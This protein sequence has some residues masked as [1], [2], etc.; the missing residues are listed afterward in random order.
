[1]STAKDY[2]ELVSYAQ[3]QED[4]ILHTL[5]H[6]TKKGFY[7]DV[8]A[9]HETLHSV[10]KFFYERGWHGINIDPNV[11]LM[12][13]F[14][15][16]KRDLNLTVGVSNKRGKLHFREY[17]HHDGLSTLSQAIKDQHEAED[18]PYKDYDVE[19][20]T[21]KDIFS[22]NKV[23]NIDFL[24]VDVEG[25]EPEV[26]E[27]NDWKKYRPAVVTFEGTYIDK[28]REYLKSKDYHEVFFDGLNV[29]MVANERTDLKITDYSA[30]LLS[31]GY[32]MISEKRLEDEHESLK[33]EY[34]KLLEE[35]ERLARL[36]EFMP[37]RKAV[38]TTARSLRRSFRA[39]AK[40]LLPSRRT[41]QE[42]Q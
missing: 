8:G 20:I 3:N 17:P 41:A 16:R 31:H 25:F 10:T 28:C 22:K 29:Y 42:Q 36:L 9:N 2:D 6:K 26:L 32:K 5:L 34:Q 27:G 19:V 39:R 23:K 1:M 33:D 38:R 14:K 37:V 24:K 21:L 40:K 4:M 35:A 15:G 18:L 12:R 13:E 30:V 7:V 11:A